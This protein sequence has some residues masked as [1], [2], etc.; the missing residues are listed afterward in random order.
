MQK[1]LL[2]IL[3]ITSG[4]LAT[5]I[6]VP[7][8]SPS[9]QAGINSAIDGDT[10][11]V[12]PGE[13]LENIDFYGK[14]VFLS[15]HY[16][17][18]QDTSH[19][20][21]TIINGSSSNSSVVTITS[22]I[23]SNSVLNGFTVTGGQG[24]YYSDWQAY[25][26]GGVFVLG[27]AKITNNRIINNHIQSGS[28]IDGAG[29]FINSGLSNTD[30]IGPA[31]VENN[32]IAYNS[33]S[34]NAMVF[35][36]GLSLAGSGSIRISN[37]LIM[38][39]SVIGHTTSLGGGVSLWITENAIISNNTIKANTVE[40]VNPIDRLSGGGG[41]FILG[42][43]PIIVGNVVVDNTAQFG[44]AIAAWGDHL[45]FN[46]RL[47]NNT[48]ADNQATR[49]GGGLFLTNGHCTAINNIIWGN[50]APVD[51][52]V[53]YRGNLNIT[54]SITQDN[55]PGIG[56]IQIDPLFEDTEYYLSSSSPAI[57]AGNPDPGYYDEAD[58][59]N[60]TQ[61]LWPAMGLLQADM[62]AFGGNDTVQ[63]A[64]EPYAVKENFL[65][66]QLNNMHY[67]LAYPLD[68]DST[69]SYPLSIILHGSGQW[70]N[71]NEWQLYEGLPWRVN[72]EHYG[73]NEFTIVPQAPTQDWG[74][75]NIATV[76]SI[77]RN[78]I[79][80]YP[81]D[82]T[83]IVVTGWSM[84]GGGTWSLLNYDPELFCAA[85]SVSAV[86]GTRGATKHIP[87][88]L[89]HGS[90]D[91]SV[92]VNRSRDRIAWYESMGLTTVYAED[93]TD[94]Q[95]HN[96]I[97]NNARVVYSEFEGA[98]HYIVKHS[99]DNYF[100]YE[101][102]KKQSRKL[103]YPRETYVSYVNADSIH[104]KTTIVNP[105]EFPFEHTARVDNFGFDHIVDFMLYDDGQHG[106]SLALDGIWGNYIEMP[107]ELDK[108][109][110]GIEI[111]NLETEHDFYFQDLAKFTNVGPL[112]FES[113]ENI[114][115]AG[116][117]I[118]AG[119]SIYFYITIQN[120]GSTTAVEDIM[121]EIQSAD[122]NARV[123]SGY[124][125]SMVED[126][127]PGGVG[128]TLSYLGLITS[129]ECEEGTPI[130]FNVIMKSEGVPFWEDRGVL[131]GYVGL[132]ESN[133]QLPTSYGLQQNY[134]N[135]FNP[136]TKISYALPERSEVSMIIYDIRGQT[137]ID[138]VRDNLT[139]GY[140]DIKWNG[141]DHSGNPVCTGVYFCRL[142]AGDYSK[143]IKMVYLR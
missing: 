140:Y 142:Q 82:T 2:L 3:V 58:P 13:Y 62:G 54:Y 29:I 131:L 107:S 55:F 30:I 31:V 68:Y 114:H 105:H 74:S 128:T 132:D 20:S 81:I 127:P 56:N 8:D 83:R 23:D 92:D 39:N 50:T 71:D 70:G 124:M 7:A 119:V 94:T 85:V 18:G 4:L 111:R 138:L 117:A 78:V 5:I 100:L 108:Y 22:R 57:D 76:H 75:T 42:E 47:I 12:A 115:P 125:D 41:I 45:G 17:L 121:I 26:G 38:N 123:N 139:A 51:S 129:D 84:G 10:V 34:G 95:L 77:I 96:A 101:W 106:D 91:Q 86:G 110:I 35:G 43:G 48:I 87:V 21:S 28:E 88:W 49:K 44:G 66:E 61:A 72:A 126:L 52:G 143:T 120:L 40:A 104:L 1:K 65:Y 79:E 53:Y 135:P 113:L 33:L 6:N 69:S 98:D 136:T 16:V 19:I 102:L 90:A 130:Y 134:P 99:Y 103:V 32:L 24:S 27:G 133:S 80:E 122:S 60:L 63:I 15:S 46:F 93:S 118:P 37:N 89:N 97:N 116:G 14:A 59:T 64:R 67:R 25:V 112:S 109:I 36:G 9:I 137:V 11:L 73:Y 141:I